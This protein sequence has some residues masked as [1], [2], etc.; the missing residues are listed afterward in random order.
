MNLG[1]KKGDFTV[2]TTRFSAE[3]IMTALK[4]AELRVPVAGPPREAGISE[5]R[6]YR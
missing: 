4:Q 2:K 3:Q 1:V 5:L 6:F